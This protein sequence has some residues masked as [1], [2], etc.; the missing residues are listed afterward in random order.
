MSNQPRQIVK[1][2]NNYSLN[3]NNFHDINNNFLN[4]I[5]SQMNNVIGS[6]AVGKVYLVENGQYVVK[7]SSPCYYDLPQLIPYCTDIIQLIQGNPLLLIPSGKK[8]R[9]ILPNLLS[10]SVIGMIFEISSI[11]VHF[12]GILGTFIL[13]DNNNQPT[14]YNIMNA[15]TPIF[16]KLPNNS[17]DLNPAIL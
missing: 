7:E 3:I 6:G 5:Y 8:Y 15:Y 4:T 12:S 10:E 16:R 2:I 9:Y 11:S 17:K 1:A 13:L 14:V